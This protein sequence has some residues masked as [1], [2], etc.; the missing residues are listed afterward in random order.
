M[1]AIC[2]QD[3][4]GCEAEI[5]SLKD[6][7]DRGKMRASGGRVSGEQT[8]LSEWNE[9]VTQWLKEEE[10]PSQTVNPQSLRTKTQNCS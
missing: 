6:E 5:D 3:Q 7:E 1:N 10:K 8:G 4:R 2:K 9:D